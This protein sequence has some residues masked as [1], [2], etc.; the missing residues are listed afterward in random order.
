M[1]A[2][3]AAEDPV[4]GGEV[5]GPRPLSRVERA[6]QWAGAEDGRDVREC[7]GH[8]GHRDAVHNRP[9]LFVEHEWPVHD[10]PVRW[11]PAPRNAH[12]DPR[13]G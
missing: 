5:E 11:P 8:R 2:G 4:D 6:L 13:R 7:S 3:Q 12:F 9:V 1:G 10:D